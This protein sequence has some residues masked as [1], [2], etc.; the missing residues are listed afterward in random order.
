MVL[1]QQPFHLLLMLVER[2][3]AM[4][5]REEIQSR[6]WPNDTIVEFNHSINVAIGKLRRAMGDSAAIRSTSRL[7]PA[8][9]TG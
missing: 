1:A 8:A 4:V 2:E 5:T 6:F 3:G 7:W 9:A